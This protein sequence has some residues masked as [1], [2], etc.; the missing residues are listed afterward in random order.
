MLTGLG[1]QPINHSLILHKGI[2]YLL[3][4]VISLSLP[5]FPKEAIFLLFTEC[6]LSYSEMEDIW[7]PGFGRRW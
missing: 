1:I 2:T 7:S 5:K 3:L 6:F 4:G